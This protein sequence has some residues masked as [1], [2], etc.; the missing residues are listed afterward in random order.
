MIYAKTGVFIEKNMFICQ[1]DEKY[2][3]LL[4]RSFSSQI[5]VYF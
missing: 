1:E 2:F 5:L 4:N 3:A